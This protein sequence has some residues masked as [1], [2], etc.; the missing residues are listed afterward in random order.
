MAA[1]IALLGGEL[2]HEQFEHFHAL[3]DFQHHVLHIEKLENSD[4][5]GSHLTADPFE[6]PSDVDPLDIKAGII[7]DCETGQTSMTFGAQF[8]IQGIFKM[9][10]QNVLVITDWTAHAQTVEEYNADCSTDDPCAR[11]KELECC[12]DKLVKEE[13]CVA[14]D[15]GD[16]AVRFEPKSKDHLAALQR[17]IGEARINCEKTKC[18][19][20]TSRGGYMKHSCY[21]HN[22]HYGR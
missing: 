17:L 7:I 4:G 6:L 20:N 2:T 1:C 9:C 11:L 22:K 15:F 8:P 12:L 19:P 3:S 10:H 13:Q 21:G 16:R 18:G 14:I 5:T